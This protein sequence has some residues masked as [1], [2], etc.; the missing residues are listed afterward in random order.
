M[1][2]VIDLRDEMFRR[3]LEQVHR[4]GVRPLYELLA[5]LG[6]QRLIRSEIEALVR[7]YSRID[8]ARLAAAGGDQWPPR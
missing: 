7:R 6:A 1:S 2:G 4:L 5:E 3:D 8:P